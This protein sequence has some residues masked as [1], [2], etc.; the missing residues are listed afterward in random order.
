MPKISCIP[1]QFLSKM[2][3]LASSGDFNIEKL[4]DK[5][6]SSEDRRKIFEKYLPKEEARFLNKD[7]EKAFSSNKGSAM[8]ELV[9]RD[10]NGKEKVSKKKDILA[11]IKSLSEKGLL[12]AGQPFYEDLVSSK[13]GISISAEEAK[14]IIEKSDELRNLS[15]QQLKLDTGETINTNSKEYA[16]KHDELMKYLQSIN[17]SHELKIFTSIWT[18]AFMLT[19]IK[20]PL[21]NIVGN[22]TMMV[23]SKGVRTIRYKMLK[24]LNG[25]LAS[26]GYRAYRQIAKETGYDYSRTRNLNEKKILGED[27]V[28][29]QGPGKFRETS[30]ALESFV[31]GK[32]LAGPDITFATAHFFDTLNLET[33]KI[34]HDKGLSG[35]KAKQYARNIMKDAMSLDP[36]TD[37][38]ANARDI[39]MQEAFYGTFTN[40]SRLSDIALQTRKWVNQVSGDISL[41][42]MIV[43]F[44][45]TPANVVSA[46]IDYAG[47]KAPL[48]IYNL[49]K[50]IKE[51]DKSKVYKAQTGLYRA[52]FGL[53]GVFILAMAIKPEDYVSEYADYYASEKQ[54]IS[55]ENATYNSIKIGNKWVSLDYFGPFAA[56]FVGI[57]NARKYGKSLGDDIFRYF[58]GIFRQALKVPGFQEV[59]DLLG[60]IQTTSKKFQEQGLAAGTDKLKNDMASFTAARLVPAIMSDIAIS[61]DDYT[62]KTDTALSQFMTRIPGIRERLPEKIGLFG[63]EIKAQPA[64]AQMLFGSRVKIANENQLVYEINR[65]ALSGFMP[66]ISS[67]EYTSERAKILKAYMGAEDFNLFLKDLGTN[68]EKSWTKLINAKAYERLPDDKKRD[69]FNKLRTKIIDAMI[70]K[71]VVKVKDEIMADKK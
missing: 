54:L 41:G 4:M 66:S 35:E 1:R 57:M 62:R 63:E 68:L 58:T 30:R 27:V 18:R 5:K 33:T 48:D 70:A 14:I 22:S 40:D 53:L 32:M 28:T 42:D 3:D 59:S 11:T 60:N 26:S 67:V 12:D 49:A 2:K 29:T 7:L 64:V 55:V 51:G 44:A 31:F 37:E 46:M 9:E 8:L 61:I 45:K 19:S 34:A 17:P 52:G 24:G 65:L 36:K 23:A 20:S 16:E 71:H 6:M 56:S 39:A 15:T 10:F 69:M 25:D 47:V 13:L 38:G 43:P 21:V 50:G